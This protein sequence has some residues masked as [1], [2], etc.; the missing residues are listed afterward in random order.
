MEE[1]KLASV[2][3]VDQQ[4]DQ[5]GIIANAAFV[6][7]LTAGRE[8]ARD[9]FGTDVVDKDGT[10]HRY[11]TKI[12]HFVRKAGQS[13]IRTIR[14]TLA[15]HLSVSMVDYPEDAAPSDYKEYT[16]NLGT[17]S[18]GEIKYRALHVIGPESIV[19]PLTKNLSR[20]D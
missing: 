5:K 19:A 12:G 3:I 2:L 8:M 18:T 13:K 16:N 14:E 1:E 4:L 6:L 15:S 20:L 11:L 9:S 10:L 7:G 17:R